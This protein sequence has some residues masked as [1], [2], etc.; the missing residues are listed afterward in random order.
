MACERLGD[1][2]VVVQ[3]VKGERALK[4][5]VDTLREQGLCLE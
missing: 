1:T 2:A 3:G 5:L 4:D